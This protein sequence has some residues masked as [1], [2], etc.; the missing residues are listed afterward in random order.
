MAGPTRIEELRNRVQKDPASIAFAQLAEEYR[1][2]GRFREAIGTC[3]AGLLRHPGYLSARV[4]LGR[5]LLEVGDLDGAQRELTEV[6]RVAPENLSAIRGLAEIHRK[7]GNLPEA[8]EHFKTAF[9]LAGKDPAI[10]QIVRDLR[11]D[12]SAVPGAAPPRGSTPSPE[13]PSLAP[14]VAAGRTPVG[15]PPAPAQRSSAPVVPPRPAVVQESPDNARA[16][17]TATYLERW[18]EAVM[19]DRRARLYA[20]RA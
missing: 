14:F 6:I 11:R 10:E 7:R 1:R 8:L 20:V 17:R 5:A 3:H 13:S 9:E 12:V 18:L 15:V 4:T 19:A 16:R 2:A